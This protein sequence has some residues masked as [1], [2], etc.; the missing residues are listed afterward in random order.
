MG[1]PM[2]IRCQKDDVPL[3]LVT[4]ADGKTWAVCP[5]CGGAAYSENV[6]KQSSGLISG[7][8][9]EEQLIDLRKQIRIADKG[10]S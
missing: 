2:L 10:V 8:L 1:K 6:I 3:A 5:V 7:M 4:A 9:T